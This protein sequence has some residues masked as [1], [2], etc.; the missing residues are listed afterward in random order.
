MDAATLHVFAACLVENEF[1]PGDRISRLEELC[2]GILLDVAAERLPLQSRPHAGRVLKLDL[3]VPVGGG[4]L[5]G[6]GRGGGGG[7][8]GGGGRERAERD[9]SESLENCGV[10]DVLKVLVYV[11]KYATEKHLQVN[12][13]RKL[14]IFK[15]NSIFLFYRRSVRTTARLPRKSIRKALYDRVK[16]VRGS[17]HPKLSSG[18][19]HVS[20]VFSNLNFEGGDGGVRDGDE[21][22]LLGREKHRGVLEPRLR[23]L[24]HRL[25]SLVALLRLALREHHAH[26]AG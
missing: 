8:G 7:G 23:A 15:D 24:G 13:H 14:T 10:C 20:R 5:E 11:D 2:L 16:V 17:H 19:I 12:S 6:R 1:V 4:G 25:P 22:E 9:L 3:V 26:A 18:D 21:D